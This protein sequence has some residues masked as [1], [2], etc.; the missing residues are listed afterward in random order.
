M[1]GS[2]YDGLKG[3]F[4]FKDITTCEVNSNIPASHESPLS[5]MTLEILKKVLLSMSL[6]LNF[7]CVCVLGVEGFHP[8]LI[9]VLHIKTLLTF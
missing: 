2:G 9:R 3:S 4:P 5:G 6:Y 8:F 7:L 1:N